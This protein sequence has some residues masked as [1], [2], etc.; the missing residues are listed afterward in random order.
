MAVLVEAISVVIKAEVIVNLYPG[1]WPAFEANSP[2]GT[3]CADGELVRVGF[4]VPNDVKAFIDSLAQYGIHYQAEGKAVDLVVVDQQR[5]F[6][7]PCDWAEFRQGPIG[8]DPKKRVA[9]CSLVGSKVSELV[10]PDGWKFEESLSAKYGFIET[11][12]NPEFLEYLG[13]ENGLD[14]YRDLR[15]GKKMYVGRTTQP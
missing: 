2:N 14:V 9:G 11:G 13:Q 7:V 10:T 1:G 12:E 15:T 6:A 4:M 5:G 3:L 8:G